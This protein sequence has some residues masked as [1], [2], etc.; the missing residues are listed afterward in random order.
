M[1]GSTLS[2]RMAMLALEQHHKGWEARREP[3]T[4]QLAA[5]RPGHT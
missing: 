5:L 1:N 2:F 4:G 3:V